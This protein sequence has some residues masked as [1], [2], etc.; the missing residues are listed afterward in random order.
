MLELNLFK[1]LKNIKHGFFTRQEG[2]SSGLFNSLNCGYG[3]GDDIQNVISN[4]SIVM[5]KFGLQYKDLNTLNQIHSARVVIAKNKWTLGERPEADAIVTETPGLAIGVLT[6][7]CVPVL[8]ADP[9][10][11]IIGACHAGWRGA[12]AGVL[13]ACVGGMEDLGARRSNI[14]AG[15]GPCIQKNSYEVDFGFRSLFLDEDVENDILFFNSIRQNH[16]Y[17]DLPGYIVKRLK[18]L[19]LKSI[20]SLFVDTY[21][22]ED[23]FFSYRRNTHRGQL[24]YGRGISVIVLSVGS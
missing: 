10:A 14:R 22:E 21:K 6:A 19:K 23:K 11:N 5:K 12:I 8:F 13:E 17:F 2:V 24:D 9:E 15:L 20:D 16:F 18:R 4:R 3:S 7:D 1:T